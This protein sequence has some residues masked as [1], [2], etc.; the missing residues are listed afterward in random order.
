MI[1][2][3]FY[4]QPRHYQQISKGFLF[5][6]KKGISYLCLKTRERGSFFIYFLPKVNPHLFAPK[7]RNFSLNMASLVKKLLKRFGSDPWMG[8]DYP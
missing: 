7:I 5:S 4:P 1:D 3:W 8:W 2:V 6:E